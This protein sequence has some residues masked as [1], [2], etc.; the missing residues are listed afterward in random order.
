[1]IRKIVASA[2]S[3]LLALGLLA[4]CTTPAEDQVGV[5]IAL[6]PHPLPVKAVE[7]NPY[8]ADIDNSIHNDVY[9]TD[10]TD[11]AAPLGICS[12]V[13]TSL[14]TENIHAPS[15]AFYDSVDNAITPF[16]GGIAITDMD[17]NTITRSGSFVPAR[18][19]GGGYSFQISYSF[20]DWADRVVAPTSHGHLLALKTMDEEGQV[21]ST[22]E[23]AMDVNIVEQAVKAL[24]GD[25]DQRL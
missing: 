16:L 24:G 7:T 11:A 21:L 1:M 25:I 3:A 18:D 6:V 8:M 9:S 19:D 2:C 4:G 13:T 20:V 14:E 15:V 17:G 12:Q 5:Q 10:V 23:K 22:F